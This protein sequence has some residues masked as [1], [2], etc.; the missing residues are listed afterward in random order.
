MPSIRIT[1]AFTLTISTT[2]TLSAAAATSKHFPPAKSKKTS[3]SAT[4]SPIKA[5]SH[6]TP[7]PKP[8]ANN[9][10]YAMIHPVADMQMW[11]YEAARNYRYPIPTDFQ[12]GY[13]DP[14]G[15]RQFP[16]NFEIAHSFVD[17]KAAAVI[18]I[19]SSSGRS[20]FKIL[21]D[22]HKDGS[23]TESPK[24]NLK[25]QE[26]V[27]QDEGLIGTSEGMT[28][29]KNDDF[30]RQWQMRMA[31]PEN[32]NLSFVSYAYTDEKTKT[33]LEKHIGAK[34]DESFNHATL[35]NNGLATIGMGSKYGLIDKTGKLIIPCQYDWLGT[36]SQG[37]IPF[38]AT[39]QNGEPRVGYIDQTGK[40]IIPARFK[41]AR[42]FG[43]DLAPA[44]ENG[45]DWGFIDKTG[46]F[47]LPP[48]Y[49]KA[50]PFKDGFALVYFKPDAKF[51]AETTL[52]S[53]LMSPVRYRDLG[54]INE[55][56]REALCVV[57]AN[58]DPKSVARAQ[59]LL[60]T[61]LPDHEIDAEIQKDYRRALD[62]IELDNDWDKAETLMASC[63]Q[64][65][66]KFLN[67]TSPL[68]LIYM[69]KQ[70][71]DEAKALLDKTLASNPD[72]G[73]AHLRMAE[74]WKLKG[75]EASAKEAMD[76]YRESEPDDPR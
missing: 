14:S 5:K 4:H 11:F 8:S 72:Y 43:N 32:K 13:I 24:S 63:L 49:A 45:R 60:R 51:E 12:F 42:E 55:A 52:P 15:K 69:H 33:I 29:R 59:L 40:V 18:E 10:G 48:I 30:M 71:I 1:I 54:L 16:Y 22:L 36:L 65:D 39:S 56:R 19:S 21:A 66:P 64:R 75:D 47:I 35:F 50:Q 20:T 9:N 7:S 2:I 76:K 6:M 61:A 34:A 38:E 70:K 27:N 26:Q 53:E 67:A 23:I 68:A 28:L 41:D 57:A 46:N 62:Y 31:H 58:R 74:Y 3:Y 17:G 44:T 37:L 73:R 25:P